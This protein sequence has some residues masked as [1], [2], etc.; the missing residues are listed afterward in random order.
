MGH[1]RNTGPDMNPDGGARAC[2]NKTD[3]TSATWHSLSTESAGDEQKENNGMY[4]SVAKTLLRYAGFFNRWRG[5][6]SCAL[7]E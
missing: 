3:K 1:D 5:F 6:H 7:C 4:I 2:N